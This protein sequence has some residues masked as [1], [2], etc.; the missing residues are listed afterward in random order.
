MAKGDIPI[1]PKHGLNPSLLMCPMCGKDVGVAICG[2]LPNDAEAPRKLV[3]IQPCDAC[4]DM[5]IEWQSKGALFVVV[6][7]EYD[8]EKKDTES[9]WPYF[10]SFH[11]LKQEAIDRWN[12]TEDGQA[13]PMKDKN[14]VSLATAKI[15]G[16]VTEEGEVREP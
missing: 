9:F 16:L 2:K 5:M 7:D 12:E 15:L 4:T 3:D 6:R 8:F 11:V 10:H 1:S 13:C 14:I